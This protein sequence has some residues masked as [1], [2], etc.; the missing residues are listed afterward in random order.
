M[1]IISISKILVTPPNSASGVGW[2]I[3]W[4]NT[5]KKSIKYARFEVVPYTR[6]GEIATCEI[7]DYSNFTGKVTGPVKP[8]ATHGRKRSWS[9]SWYNNTIDKIELVRIDIEY[10]DGSTEVLL[11]ENIR[12]VMK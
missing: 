10:M 4:K 3:I 1:N 5:S 9:N 12:H 6:V 11:K 8:G 2:S 7:R